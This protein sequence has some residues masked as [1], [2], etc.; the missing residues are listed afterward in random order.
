[1][2]PNANAYFQTVTYWLREVFIEPPPTFVIA[3]TA[4]PVAFWYARSKA[5]EVRIKKGFEQNTHKKVYL[6]ICTG[7]PENDHFEVTTPLSLQ[8][9]RGLVRI[10]MISDE[11]GLPCH[12]RFDVLH[13]DFAT[14]QSLVM[15]QPLTGRQHQIRAHLAH[16]G[17]PI[18]GDKLYKMGEAFFDAMTQSKDSLA[19]LLEHDRHALHAFAITLDGPK[20]VHF[21]APFSL[22]LLNLMPSLKNP[23]ILTMVGQALRRHL[24]FLPTNAWYAQ[25]QETQT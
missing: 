10:K 15:V 21:W 3:S 17:H 7:H 16:V 5:F 19:H 23:E 20:P 18:V 1:M 13:K 12:T 22:D 25:N 14:Q 4:K 2:H 24:P 9:D 8:G 6:A 11:A